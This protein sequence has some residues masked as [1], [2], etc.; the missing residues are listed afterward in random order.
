MQDGFNRSDLLVK[1][2][3]NLRTAE[4]VNTAQTVLLDGY[5]LT[6]IEDRNTDGRPTA[7]HTFNP[8]VKRAAYLLPL[9]SGSP[10]CM[11]MGFIPFFGGRSLSFSKV[12]GLLGKIASMVYGGRS[13]EPT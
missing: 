13:Y 1:E 2:W 3:E 9:L 12:D 6:A 11:P 10:R 8:K 4:E 7:R 5:W